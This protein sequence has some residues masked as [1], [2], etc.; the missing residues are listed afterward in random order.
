MG[1]TKILVFKNNEALKD[2]HKPNNKL[3]QTRLE[4]HIMMQ[5]MAIKSSISLLKKKH[6]PGKN[7][8]SRKYFQRK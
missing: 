2:A 4:S 6:F 1:W 7:I 8:F 3:N 5:F